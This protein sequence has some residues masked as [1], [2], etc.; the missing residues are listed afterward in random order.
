MEEPKPETETLTVTGSDDIFEK[1]IKRE[2]YLDEE[3]TISLKISNNPAIFT[4]NLAP[5]LL[6]GTAR[7]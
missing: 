5:A 7:R 3:R 2:L 1:P 6:S 4:I